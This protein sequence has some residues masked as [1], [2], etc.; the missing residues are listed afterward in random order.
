MR[1]AIDPS[2]ALGR[3]HRAALAVSPDAV[4]TLPIPVRLTGGGTVRALVAI[5]ED[6]DRPASDAVVDLEKRELQKER[7]GFRLDVYGTAARVEAGP[8]H[9]SK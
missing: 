2:S 6:V 7:Y 1:A 9:G 3:A 5:K 4:L 8:A